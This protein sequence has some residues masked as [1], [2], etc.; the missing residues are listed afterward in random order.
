MAPTPLFVFKSLFQ[1]GDPISSVISIRKGLE[2]NLSGE[3]VGVS[4]EFCGFRPE[5]SG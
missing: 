2:K 4:E 1:A 3:K 5:N